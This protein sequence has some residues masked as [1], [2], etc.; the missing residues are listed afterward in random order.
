MTRDEFCEKLSKI[1]NDVEDL[2][3]FVHPCNAPD[4]DEIIAAFEA[5]KA[6]GFGDGVTDLGKVLKDHYER[7]GLNFKP[8]ASAQVDSIR[9]IGD[10]DHFVNVVFQKAV[11]NL[12]QDY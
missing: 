3:K 5:G 1:H 12:P 10:I 9:V 8:F 11:D 4:H 6:L 7:L 2:K